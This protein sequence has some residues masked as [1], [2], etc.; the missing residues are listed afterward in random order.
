MCHRFVQSGYPRSKEKGGV[1]ERLR[2]ATGTRRSQA[3]DG[4]DARVDLEPGSRLEGKRPPMG[5]AFDQSGLGL[6][7]GQ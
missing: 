1:E 4:R 3:R 6:S 5:A 7:P 2:P